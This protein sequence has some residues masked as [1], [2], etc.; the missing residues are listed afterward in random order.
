MS[1]YFIILHGATLDIKRSITI[2][3]N[4]TGIYKIHIIGFLCYNFYKIGGGVFFMKR[5]ALKTFLIF[6]TLIAI[7]T[8]LYMVVLFPSHNY[9]ANT[10][11]DGSF[12]VS[13]ILKKS[14]P[15]NLSIENRNF[16]TTISLTEDEL[17][18]LIL[19]EI[20]KSGRDVDG[21]EVSIDNNEMNIYVSQKVG[22]YFPT[23]LSLLFT[24]EVKDDS[25]KLILNNAKLGK[26]N[27]NVETVLNKIK[28]SKIRFFNV[29]PLDSEIILEDQELKSLITANAIKLDQHKASVDVKLEI[30]SIGDLMKLMDLVTKKE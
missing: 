1:R 30:N 20:N 17:R 26:L 29:K 11:V 5:K 19:S 21:V 28:D 4:Y 16:K 8:I 18:S 13:A 15:K 9:R 7:I 24:T 2:Y 27:L 12:D 6:M 3:Y 14:I 23:E 22:K 25:V 10:D